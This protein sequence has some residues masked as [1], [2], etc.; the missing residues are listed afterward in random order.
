[1]KGRGNNQFYYFLTQKGASLLP[2]LEGIGK[3]NVVFH[4]RSFARQ[5]HSFSGLRSDG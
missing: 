1:M 4:P 2:E 3:K 5:A